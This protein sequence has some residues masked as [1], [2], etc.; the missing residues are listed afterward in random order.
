MKSFFGGGSRDDDEPPKRQNS[1]QDGY[2]GAY[3]SGYPGQ[4]ER[5]G[6]PQSPHINQQYG[7]QTH[8]P[9]TSQAP[10]QPQ[11]QQSGQQPQSS[12]G[13]LSML[14][15][16]FSRSP[17]PQQ[18]YQHQRQQ[19]AFEAPQQDMFSSLDKETL[20]TL[21]E[22]DRNPD[23][24]YEYFAEQ[25]STKELFRESLAL[26]R[27]NREAAEQ[28]LARAKRID[29][30]KEE[31]LASQGSVQ[32]MSAE[33]NALVGS[34]NDL[35]RQHSSDTYVRMLKEELARAEDELQSF[36]ETEAPK[37]ELCYDELSK[38]VE[39]RKLSIHQVSYSLSRLQK[40]QQQSAPLTVQPQQ[41]PPPQP[42]Y[43]QGMQYM[44]Q[45]YNAYQQQYQSPGS[46][47]YG[48]QQPDA[49]RR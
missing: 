35:A 25:V 2:P 49:Y 3:M 4:G 46:M 29:V 48:A 31:I 39:K 43:A 22:L 38:H 21:R 26:Q 12:G 13:F 5:G 36:L 11:R 42:Q 28:N 1:P 6:S 7:Q 17:Q 32:R 19:Q 16:P 20:V 14:T 24:L 45:Q 44:P 40:Q 33:L 18:Q 9:Y 15:A 30:L 8:I 34:K 10:Y 23:K 27:Q 41:P 37:A 47:A